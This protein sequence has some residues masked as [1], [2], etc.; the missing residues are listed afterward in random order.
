MKFTYTKEDGTV[1]ETTPERWV[2]LAIYKDGSYLKQ[3]DEKEGKYHFF[4]EIDQENLDHF[5]MQRA[6]DPTRRFEMK[7][8][9]GWDLIH[10]YRNKKL[11]IGTDQEQHI[12]LYCFGYKE[13]IGKRSRKT[14]M[15]I[16]PNDVVAIVGDDGRGDK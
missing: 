15:Q 4:K 14:I 11:N 9:K 13:K 12:K 3:F 2:W 1:K 5:V 16:Y 10:Y 6:D 8:E 7:F